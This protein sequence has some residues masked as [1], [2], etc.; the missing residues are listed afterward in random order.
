MT[1][2]ELIASL[3]E[4]SDEQLDMTVTV[5]LSNS[6]EWIAGEFKFV[7]DDTTLDSGH[8]VITCDF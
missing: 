8:P 4:L 5:E 6:D 3:S 2:R 7:D 1:Y